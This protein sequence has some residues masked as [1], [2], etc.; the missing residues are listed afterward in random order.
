MAWATPMKRNVRN[1]S[2]GDLRLSEWGNS[3]S[4]I[5]FVKQLMLLNAWIPTMASAAKGAAIR[6]LKYS[7]Y[8]S[9]SST[10]QKRMSQEPALTPRLQH[11]ATPPHHL[12]VTSTA[13]S[14]AP[15]RNTL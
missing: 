8:I 10:S 1:G 15:P 12:A 5:R 6:S 3:A 14:Q 2:F 7:G 11:H 13:T 9:A 4:R